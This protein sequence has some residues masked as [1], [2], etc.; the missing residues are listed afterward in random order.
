M[1][2]EGDLCLVL[3]DDDF[4]NYRFGDVDFVREYIGNFPSHE[5][6]NVLI[7]SDGFI[8]ARDFTNLDTQACGD[9]VIERQ[10]FTYGL[11]GKMLYNPQLGN[12]YFLAL[13]NAHFNADCT[14]LMDAMA[15]AGKV[16]PQIDKQYYVNG[17][18]TWYPEASWSSPATFGYLNIQR[19]MRSTNPYPYGHTMSIADYAVAASKGEVVTDLMT[20]PEVSDNLRSFGEAALAAVRKAESADMSSMTDIQR[21]EYK[22]FVS[23][24]EA[25]A[26][27]GLYYSEKILAAVD[28]RILN[29]TSDENYRSSAIGHLKTAL[30]YWKAYAGIQGT[31]YRPQRLCRQGYVDL[32]EITKSVENDISLAEKWKIKKL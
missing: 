4:Y 11:W 15:A 19:W 6:I 3:R 5:R 13:L 14:D 30:E 17:D 32:N 25:M 7:G 22:Q 20:P 29:E 8:Q 26:Y 21:R 2:R 16:I 31:K 28:M 24:Q 27:L 12:D 10:W 18:A 1:D 23:D 9:L